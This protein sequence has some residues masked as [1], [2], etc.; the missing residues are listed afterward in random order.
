MKRAVIVAGL[1]VFSLILPLVMMGALLVGA[2]EQTS[3]SRRAL[4]EIPRELLPVYVAAA[5]S[6]E[7][8]DWTVLAAIHRLE[9]NFG[10][11]PAISTAGAQG[12]MQFMPDTF[13]SYGVDGNGD[14]TVEVN[15]P[16]DAIFSAANLL[17]ANGGG[18]HARLADAVWTYNH[19]HAYVAEVLR[20]ATAYGVV[21]FAA[22]GTYASPQRLLNNPRIALSASARADVAAGLVD[23]R[24]ISL[25]QALS[26]RQTLSV[27]VFKTGHS[28]YTRSGSVSNHHYGRAADVFFI[29][30]LPVS[31]SSLVARRFTQGISTIRGPLRPDEIGHP[32][33][34]LDFA[35]GF[36]D[37]DH[38]DHIHIGY[39]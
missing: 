8:L 32:F 5:A 16:V 23:P 38:Q 10:T 3:P 34:G 29:D 4:G 39:D 12:P 9:T 26:A 31:S 20:L 15:D 25:L 7:G 22:G 18:D 28:M 24:L 35:E 1:L 6:C 27:S 2:G 30:G 17:C 13:E 37:V 36:S 11:G 19:S 14:G 21:R 33:G